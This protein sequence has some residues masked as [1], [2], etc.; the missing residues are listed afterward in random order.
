MVGGVCNLYVRPPLTSNSNCC[1]SP[2][3]KALDSSGGTPDTGSLHPVAEAV[4]SS[5]DR[6]A[7]FYCV[8]PGQPMSL[9]EVAGNA[10]ENSSGDFCDLGKANTTFTSVL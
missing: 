1:N 3:R 8:D 4:T 10:I 6:G 7:F 2:P 9:A 5:L